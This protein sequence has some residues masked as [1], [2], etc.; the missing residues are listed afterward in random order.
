M[1]I[2]NYKVHY[3]RL[4]N[5]A[6]HRSFTGYIEKHHIK[7]RCLGGSDSKHNIVSLTARE[8]FV[9]HQLLVKMY[10]DEPKLVYA[11]HMMTVGYNGKRVHNR[12]Y[13]WLRRRHSK[14]LSKSMG[15]ENHP[16]YG[17]TRPEHSRFMKNLGIRPPDMTGWKPTAKECA[18]RAA[19]GKIQQNFRHGRGVY[20]SKGLIGI[21]D[22][23]HY[24]HY[25]PSRRIPNGWK[26]GKPDSM[27]VIHQKSYT[28][29]QH[30][31]REQP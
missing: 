8:H 24:Q 18:N 25:D 21:T 19:R 17:K 1:K 28:G 29:N 23:I 15:G 22:G 12:M 2:M 5:R 10:P 14:V 26:R 30:S 11:A 13:E 3:E 9:A 27:K 20:S 6:K 31:Q 4:I 7:P 16:F